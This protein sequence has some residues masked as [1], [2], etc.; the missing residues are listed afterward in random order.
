VI[1]LLAERGFGDVYDSWDGQI[2]TALAWE[3]APGH[4]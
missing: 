1:A 4:T 2:D 3:F